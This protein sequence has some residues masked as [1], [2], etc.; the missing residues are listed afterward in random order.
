VSFSISIRVA[1]VSKLKRAVGWE[2][3]V[4]REWKLIIWVVSVGIEQERPE[5]EIIVV[6]GQETQETSGSL[7]VLY[8][9]R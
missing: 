8:Q 9:D 5:W 7:P 4:V 1:E 6:V 2:G 3:M